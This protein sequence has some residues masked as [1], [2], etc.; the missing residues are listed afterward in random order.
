MS[1]S[2]PIDHLTDY[3]YTGPADA[4]TVAK[5]RVHMRRWL[6]ATVVIDAQQVAD[7][8]LAVDEALS[9]CAEHAYCDHDSASG[10]GMTLDLSYDRAEETVQVCVTDRGSW[11]EPDPAAI[12]A[13]RGRG[14][15]LMHALA[16]ECTVRGRSDGTTAWLHFH[17]CPAL[18]GAAILAS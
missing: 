1:D 15:I 16:D 17:H 4:D 10:G 9:N 11:V 18:D 5:F 6:D 13:V 14:L 8:V 2:A 7:I 12:N 3:S